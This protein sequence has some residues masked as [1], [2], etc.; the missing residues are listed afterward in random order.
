MTEQT[1]RRFN[2]VSAYMNNQTE[3]QWQKMLAEIGETV[4]VLEDNNS[5][6]EPQRQIKVRVQFQ[7]VESDA[8]DGGRSGFLYIM[9]EGYGEADAA[10][11]HGSPVFME[12]WE[13]ELR[14]IVRPDILDN[15]DRTQTII[16]LEDA[17]EDRVTDWDS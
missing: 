6:H 10:R 15:E 13:G 17:R 8:P 9:P 14:V 3:E 7:K 11:G 16:P 12:I 4:G 2:I 1:L 5:E